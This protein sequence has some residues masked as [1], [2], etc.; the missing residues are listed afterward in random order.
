[1]NNNI[2]SIIISQLPQIVK[3]ATHHEVVAQWLKEINTYCVNKHGKTFLEMSSKEVEA[4]A[5]LLEVSLN[6]LFKIKETPFIFLG[7]AGV[8]KT[9]VVTELAKELGYQYRYIS[10]K[11][12]NIIGYS[13][14][15]TEAK[16]CRVYSDADLFPHNLYAPTIYHLDEFNHADPE[17][18][19]ALYTLVDHRKLGQQKLNDMDIFVLTGN[20]AE[21]NGLS[22][23]IPQ[24]F[25]NRCGFYKIDHNHDKVVEFFMGLI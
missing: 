12:D 1:M 17:R 18:Q 19:S 22:Y 14:P 6:N 2:P 8:G 7:K 23:P 16:V 11:N 20:T 5:S 13:I 10:V 25:I 9:Q 15:D 3:D 21:D 24:P 4:D